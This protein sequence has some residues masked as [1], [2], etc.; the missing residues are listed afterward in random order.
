MRVE[1]LLVARR[2]QS[3]VKS[4][5]TSFDSQEEA[6]G[7]DKEWRSWKRFFDWKWRD[8]TMVGILIMFFQRA[9]KLCISLSRLIYLC[10]EWS[11]INALLYYGP[12]LVQSIGFQGDQVSLLVSGGIGIVQL[13]A[14]LP[15][16]VWIDHIGTLFF[17][18][19]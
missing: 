11:G 1:V 3:E 16:I 9:F 14:V 17:V 5:Q 15:A 7:W 8:R 13:L 2:M 19:E 4:G 6:R 18:H 12:T 10:T